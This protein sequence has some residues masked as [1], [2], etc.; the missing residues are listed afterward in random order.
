VQICAPRK[1]FAGVA[2]EFERHPQVVSGLNIRVNSCGRKLLAEN[3]PQIDTDPHE[4]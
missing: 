2:S 1:E 4:F 3:G